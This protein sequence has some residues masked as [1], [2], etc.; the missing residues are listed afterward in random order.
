MKLGS[1]LIR[2]LVGP[3]FIAHGG[4]KLFGWF[5]GP[6]LEGTSGFFE[7]IGLRPGRRHATAAGVTEAAAGTMLTLGLATPVAATMVSATMVTAIRKVHLKAGPW[8]SNGGWEF[9]AVVIA[10]VAGLA[11]AGPGPLSIDAKRFPN[12]HGPAL[13]ALVLAGGLAG[14]Y[15]GTH[16]AVNP[17]GP[18]PSEG[19]G[20]VAGD[21]ATQG[22]APS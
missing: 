19:E 22:A 11:D 20:E 17:P 10:A 14:S 5:G 2:G 8:A 15:L 16:P 6:G 9:N 1:L 13:A 4:Q 3:L 18:A 12:L 21:P 7:S